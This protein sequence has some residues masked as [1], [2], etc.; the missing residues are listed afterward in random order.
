MVCLEGVGGA[1][2]TD[3]EREKRENSRQWRE[4]EEMMMKSFLWGPA[5][6]LRA[7]LC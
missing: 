1:W 4:R 5:L 7:R 3:Y 6:L 2:K